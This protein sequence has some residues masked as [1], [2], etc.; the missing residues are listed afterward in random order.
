MQLAITVQVRGG[1][2]RRCALCRDA[3]A[4]GPEV[5]CEGCGVLVHRE[6]GAWVT[7]CPSLGCAGSVSPPVV[8]F[9]RRVGRCCGRLAARC[10]R[11]RGLL[12]GWALLLGALLTLALVDR[13]PGPPLP[14]KPPRAH[15]SDITARIR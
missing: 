2:R 12:L 13:G 1:A 4:S 6:C 11:Q 8:S 15:R 14:R 7:R 5:R 10:R 9:E 3:L